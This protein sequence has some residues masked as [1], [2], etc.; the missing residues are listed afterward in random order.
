MVSRKT[1]TRVA[2]CAALGCAA[3]AA[4]AQA[5][6]PNVVLIVA[7]D[8]GVGDVRYLQPGS[9]AT[10]NLDRLAQESTVFKNAYVTAAVCSPSRA[11]LLTGRYQARFGHDFNPGSASDQVEMSLPPEVQTIAGRLQRSGYF[12]GLIGKW[13]LEGRR[14]GA[15]PMERG[16]DE[17]FGFASGGSYILNPREGD[18]MLRTEGEPAERTR[19][20]GFVRMGKPVEIDGYKTDVLSTEALGFLAKADARDQPFFLVLAHHAPHVPLEATKKYMDRV[21]QVQDPQQR[22]YAAMITAL[23]DSVGAIVRDLERRGLREE[24]L[25]LFLSDNGCPPYIA[26]ACSNA[27]FNGHK[28]DF[29]EGGIRSPFMI[30]WPKG[31]KAPR[32]YEKPVISL[33]LAATILGAAGLDAQ[34]KEIDGVDLKAYVGNP[35]KRPHDALYWRAGTDVAIRRGDWK[36]IQLDVSAGGRATFLFDLKNDPKELRNLAEARPDKVRELEAEWR[37]WNQG[38]IPSRMKGR[39]TTSRIAGVEVQARY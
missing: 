22:V 19:S 14:A 24:T 3:T 30:S 9:F 1:L 5:R 2:I 39:V 20:Q 10:P 4:T 6:T 25:I 28:R 17:Y 32:A 18:V 29:G 11:G 26:E 23:D 31:Q 12:T 7:D 37:R 38:N 36:L 16:F 8:L 35:E 15:S 13:H 33:D 27:P 34:I 21:T